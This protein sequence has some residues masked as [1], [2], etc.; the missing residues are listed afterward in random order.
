MRPVFGLIGAVWVGLLTTVGGHSAETL[1]L[2]A[3]P[4]AAAVAPVLEPAPYC[5]I[6]GSPPGRWFTQMVYDAARRVSLLYGGELSLVPGTGSTAS[7]TWTWDGAGWTQQRPTTAPPFANSEAL[8]YDEKRGLAVLVVTNLTWTWDGTDWTSRRTDHLPPPRGGQTMAYDPDLEG[9]VMFGGAVQDHD[10]SDTWLWDGND[11]KQLAGDLFPAAG[12]VYAATAYHPGTHRL[13]LAVS[14]GG[15]GVETYEF[16][17][18][19]WQRVRVPVFAGSGQARMVSDSARGVLLHM[20]GLG[21]G[22]HVW[23][24]RSWTAR[25][26]NTRVVD[27]QRTWPGMAY[28]AERKRVVLFGGLDAPRICPRADTLL[29]DGARWS[30]WHAGA[31]LGLPG[32]AVVGTWPDWSGSLWGI[33]EHLTGDGDRWPELY[34]ANRE[35]IGPQPSLIRTGTE[36]LLPA[37]W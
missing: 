23:D 18:G 11:W 7:D 35:A 36:L 17:D 22:Y 15:S 1:P 37:D 10:F 6:P 28:D 14:H 12:R 32:S 33:A 30:E 34:A 5:A 4:V 29:W 20:D 2:P 25:A 27:L 3:L 16:V 24:G 9:V 26:A 31:P 13:V 8:A 21:N 19:A